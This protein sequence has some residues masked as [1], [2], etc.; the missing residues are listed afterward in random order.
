MVFVSP[1]V[2]LKLL[3]IH[4]SLLSKPIEMALAPP[5]PKSNAIHTANNRCS[6]L[7]L[8]GHSDTGEVSAM[9]TYDPSLCVPI[10]LATVDITLH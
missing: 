5:S 10:V 3:S 2:C 1:K 4:D 9:C 7:H 6:H 8:D